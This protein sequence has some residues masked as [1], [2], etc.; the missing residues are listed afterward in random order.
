MGHPVVEHNTPRNEW[1]VHFFKPIASAGPSQPIY[2]SIYLFLSIY[3]SIRDYTHLLE[4]QDP[5]HFTVNKIRRCFLYNNQ[6]FQVRHY[7]V[8]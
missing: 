3:P 4:Q 1:L 6:Y 5:L 8:S 2:L 7:V